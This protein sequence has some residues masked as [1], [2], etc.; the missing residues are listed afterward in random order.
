MPEQARDDLK[1]VVRS[2]L[3][4][5]DIIRNLLAFARQEPARDDE[6]EPGEFARDLLAFFAP[7][8]GRKRIT[9]VQEISDRLPVLRADAA[10]LRQVFVNLLLNAVQA[11]PEGGTLTVRV[12]QAAAGLRLQVVDTGSGMS[13]EVRRRAFDPFF[14]TKD[15]NEGTGLGLAVV[16]GIVAGHGGHIEI[17]SAP[18]AG[19]TFTVEIP[20]LGASDLAAAGDREPTR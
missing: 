9:V 6:I 8:W 13:E 11:M 4:A 15:V 18:G 10:Q 20:W 17:E 1:K 2:S 5:R 19:S 7:R 14:T 16:H 12:G 3:D